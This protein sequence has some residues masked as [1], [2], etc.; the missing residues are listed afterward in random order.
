MINRRVA[1]PGLREGYDLWS[2]TYDQTPNP[3]VALDRRFT[4]GLLSPK[5]GESILDEACGTG[6]HLRTMAVARSV[7]VGLDLSQ[8]MLR[9]ARRNCLPVPLA[10]ADLERELPLR[11]GLFDAVLC[12]LVGEHLR[13]LAVLFREAFQVLKPGGRLV[14]SVFHPEMVAA[15]IES[16]FEYSG[17]EYRLGARRHSVADYVNGIADAGFRA[18]RRHEF[19]GDADLVSEVPR[20]RKYLHQPL[21]LVVEGRRGS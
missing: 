5:A 20:A 9:V 18:V 2:E 19:C 4:M 1:R 7:P 14:F 6:R 13:N 16:N 17:V 10:Q 8:S 12:A 15:G 11:R 21:L 3:L